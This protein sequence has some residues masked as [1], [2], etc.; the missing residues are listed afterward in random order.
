M[1]ETCQVCN[2]FIIAGSCKCEYNKKHGIHNF[3]TICEMVESGYDIDALLYNIESLQ[4]RL[5]D[6]QI[7][8]LCNYFSEHTKS[9]SEANKLFTELHHMNEVL[10]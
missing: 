1:T 7:Q 2:G 4:A 8:T 5:T 10:A 3:H 9:L 6:R